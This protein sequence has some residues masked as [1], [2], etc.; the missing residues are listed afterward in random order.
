M[1]HEYF[2][3]AEQCAC[4]LV[5]MRW[6][7]GRPGFVLL[8][9]VVT[10]IRMGQPSFEE[11]PERRAIRVAVRGGLLVD[12]VSRASLRIAF[13]RGPDSL[14]ASVE[15]RDY[16]PR[17]GQLAVGDWLYRNTQVHVHE[18]VGLRYVRQLRRRWLAQAEGG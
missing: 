14:W 16:V 4:G 9:P 2:R 5:R 6:S 18:W 1:L 7:G 8:W 12:P 15:L 13:T 3:V 11:T 10:I 17:A